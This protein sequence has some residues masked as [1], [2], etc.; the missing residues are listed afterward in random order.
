MTTSTPS[1]STVVSQQAPT[2]WADA[3][4]VTFTGRVA[5]AELVSGRYGEFV[6]LSVLSRPVQDDDDSQVA[7]V[8]NSSQ[9][10]PFFKSGGIPV[11]R[12]VTVTGNMAGIEASY[13]N[14]DGVIVPLKRPRVRLN[15]SIVQ[16]GQKPSRK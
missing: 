7:V 13:T 6:S 10:V 9:L 5:N 12:A 3:N 1:T 8:F 11:G 14:K 2:R 15:E 4:S 16:W